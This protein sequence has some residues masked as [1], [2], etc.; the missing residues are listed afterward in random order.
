M[1]IKLGRWHVCVI[2]SEI[3]IQREHVLSFVGHDTGL[4]ILS[5]SLFKEVCFP[6]KGNVLHEVKGI[7]NIEYLQNVLTQH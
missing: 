4:L 5:Y 7:F 1:Y 3:C 6:F 2:T